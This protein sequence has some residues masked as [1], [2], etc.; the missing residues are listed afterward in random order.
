MIGGAGSIDHGV[1]DP[2]LCDRATGVNTRK[3]SMNAH[4]DVPSS[5]RF[6][7]YILVGPKLSKPGVKA[8]SAIAAAVRAG[9]LGVDVLE[10]VAKKLGLSV[11]RG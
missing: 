2:V 8:V 7:P 5:Y 11:K 4:I 6:G 1:I 9:A 3:L 10:S